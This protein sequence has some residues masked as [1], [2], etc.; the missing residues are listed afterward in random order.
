MNILDL[1]RFKGIVIAN[2][3]FLLFVAVVLTLNFN[4]AGRLASTGVAVKHAAQQ[5]VQPRVIDANARLLGSKLASHEDI[6]GALDELRRSANAYDEALAS[7]LNGGVVDE[8]GKVLSVGALRSSEAVAQLQ[9]SAKLWG[10]YKTKLEPVL[11]FAGSPYVTNTPS[12]DPTAAP[13]ESVAA[14]SPR[15]KRLE[16][17]VAELNTLSA[18]LQP[19]LAKASSDLTAALERSNQSLA[20]SLRLVQV[21]GVVVALA[22][23][24]SIFFYFARNLR[25]DE[26]ESNRARKETQDILRTV[27]EGLF[28][29]D[30]DLK[31]GT[32]RSMALSTIFRR[33]DLTGLTFDQL[34]RNIVPEKTLKTAQDYVALL[35]GERVN[36]K[37]VKTINPLSEVEV[38]FDNPNGGFDTHF[39]E[40]DF[41][42]VKSDGELS[43]LLVTVCCCASC[44]S[45]PTSSRASSRMPTCR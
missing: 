16:A 27:N 5:R 30:R 39:L 38:H 23:L 40:F 18:D 17:T 7:M 8:S 33:D 3:V 11:R 45:S 36:E 13:S 41:T 32:E 2:A 44:T 20:N 25:K 29:L 43:H 37:L 22:M 35:W 34:L 4:L 9:T 15:G 26:L 12:A 6:A 42:R 10:D 31:I 14:L 1:G 28:L 24:L 19:K 21:A